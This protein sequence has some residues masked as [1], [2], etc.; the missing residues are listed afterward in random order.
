MTKLTV[1]V[2]ISKLG[3]KLPKALHPPHKGPKGLQIMKTL[4]HSKARTGNHFK[5]PD[6]VAVAAH[7]RMM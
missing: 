1:A 7:D 3:Q 2:F 6:A 5:M 4:K